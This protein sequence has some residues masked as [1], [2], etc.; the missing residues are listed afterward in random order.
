MRIRRNAGMLICYAGEGIVNGLELLCNHLGL[1]KVYCL[2]ARCHLFVGSREY[3]P[4]PN[5]PRCARF[6]PV[7]VQI[8]HRKGTHRYICQY[9]TSA[10]VTNLLAICDHL[11]YST[12][13][14]RIVVILKGYFGNRFLAETDND[15][16]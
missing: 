15:S 13:P 6:K 16:F 7:D 2:A 5:L 1:I 11:G 3:T 14:K 10:G 9:R 12:A 4:R 8:Y